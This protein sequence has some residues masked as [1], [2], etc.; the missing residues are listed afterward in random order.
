MQKSDPWVLNP[1]DTHPCEKNVWVHLKVKEYYGVCSTVQCLSATWL[2]PTPPGVNGP[3]RFTSSTPI[4]HSTYCT[5]VSVPLL[6]PQAVLAKSAS[7][8]LVSKPRE[9]L[10]SFILLDLSSALDTPSRDSLLVIW[11]RFLLA[12]VSLPLYFLSA[13]LNGSCWGF[14]FRSWVMAFISKPRNISQIFFWAPG[15]LTGHS[16]FTCFCPQDTSN[17]ASLELT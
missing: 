1:W 13:Q 11:H 3:P 15:S 16:I 12:S 7:A 5:L 6:S 17:W 9:L 4:H 10:S 8:L 2:S 14:C